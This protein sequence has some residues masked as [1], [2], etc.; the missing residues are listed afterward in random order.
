MTVFSAS[1]DILFEDTNVSLVAGWRAG[2]A[3]DPVPVRVIMRK[4]DEEVSFNRARIVVGTVWIDVRM[5]EVPV[6]AK[7]DT[8]QILGATYTV[9]G[10]PKQDDLAMNWRAE[11]RT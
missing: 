8:F 4:P 7:G 2:G 10:D 11:A 5:S 1:N 9:N 6:L 3:G